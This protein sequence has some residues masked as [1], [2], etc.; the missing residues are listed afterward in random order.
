ML[1]PWKNSYDKPR[2][3]VKKQRYYFADKGLSSQIYGFSST[4]VWMWEL[5]QK[6]GWVSKNWCF[7]TVR[8]PWSSRRSNQSNLK[9]NQPWIFTGNTEAEAPILWLSDGKSRLIGKDPDAGKEWRE[10]EKGATKDKMARWQHQLNDMS[11]S[12]LQEMVKDREASCVAVHVAA[13]S[14][15]LL[16][17]CRKDAFSGLH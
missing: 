1:V 4:H 7:G 11:L 8:V 14:W 12:K 9:K 5:D 13:K 2:Q 3:H 16:T 15:T 17:D 6:E 10:E